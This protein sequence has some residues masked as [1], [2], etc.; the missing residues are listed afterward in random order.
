MDKLLGKLDPLLAVEYFEQLVTE[1]DPITTFEEFECWIAPLKSDGCFRGHR[2][3]AWG[4]ITTLDRALFKTITVETNEVHSKKRLKLDPA[5]N[6]RA[7]FLEFQRDAHHYCANTP[8]TDRV[9]DWL[10]LMQHHGAPTRL[11]DWTRSPYVALY[12]AMEGG[13]EGDAAIWAID[14]RWLEQRSGEL[15][16]QH[17]KDYPEGSDF[18]SL[19]DY[20]SRIVFRENNP[21][22]IVPASPI[23]VNGRMVAQQGQFL[24]RLRHDVNF[25]SSLLDMLIHPI[26]ERQ[27]VSR[28]VVK[29]DQRIKFLEELRRMNIHSAALFPGLDGFAR[30]LATNLEIAVSHQVESEREAMI[31]ILRST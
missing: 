1:P 9:V 4:L 16:R 20:I 23:Q 13:S 14:W 8:P 12:F 15:L 18:R 29:R 19:C 31:K 6:E 10:A 30:S 7:V 24:C 28:V 3:A 5:E 2:E 25:S 21:Y 26:A 11:L 17:S 22:M 27:V